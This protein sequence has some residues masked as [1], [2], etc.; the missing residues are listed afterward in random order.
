MTGRQTSLDEIPSTDGED[1]SGSQASPPE[2]REPT[3]SPGPAPMELSAYLASALTSV[4]ED[5]RKELYA[6]QGRIQE[7]GRQH[8]IDI[9]LP[10]E[11]AD[12]DEHEDLTP[13]DVYGMDREAVLK[14]D[15]LIIM[16]DAP[17]HGVGMEAEIAAKALMPILLLRTDEGRVSRMLLGVPSQSHDLEVIDGSVEAA[18]ADAF[19]K[20][21]P[22]VA[23]RRDL[24]P[25][26]DETRIGDRVAQLR[27]EH[28]VSVEQLAGALHLEPKEIERLEAGPTSHVNPSL[29][30]L[31]G[32]A[33]FFDLRLAE[34]VDPAYTEHAN[35][36]LA[37]IVLSGRLEGA[38]VVARDTDDPDGE[39]PKA[40]RD[41]I[42][43]HRLDKL[44][45][46][47]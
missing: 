42:L 45:E 7:I 2:G 41:V 20:L 35:E 25:A 22:V 33:D 8:N 11:N 34:L 17:S 31:M 19:Q 26:V 37:D 4:P 18:L 21:R 6:F 13:E 32:I 23:S 10:G 47:L 16:T 44:R 9:Y 27:R 29:M 14:S 24:K 43:K 36:Q 15:F 46:S 3:S 30:M 28:D 38:T 5:E 12:P 1:G 40:D 39:I